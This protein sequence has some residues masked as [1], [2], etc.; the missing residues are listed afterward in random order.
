MGNFKNRID[1]ENINKQGLK[2][3]IIRYGSRRDI[4]IEFEDGFVLYHKLY[5]SFINGNI[6]NDSYTKKE[7]E[8]ESII[9]C[10]GLKMKI[11]EYKDSTHINIQFEDGTIIKD[12]QYISFKNGGILNPN[13]DNSR[14]INRQDEIQM[15]NNGQKCKIINYISAKDIDVLFI[16]TGEVLKH[17][18]YQ[19]FKNGEIKSHLTATVSNVGIVGNEPISDENKNILISYKKWAG[20]LERCYDDEF[21]KKYP[22]YEDVSCC[23]EWLYYS[24]FKK[25]HDDNY[26]TVGDEVMCLDKDI[27]SHNLELTSKIYSPKTCLYVPQRINSLF[28]KSYKYKGNLPIGVVLNGNKYDAQISIL[29]NRKRL[30]GFNSP[31]EAF[32]KGYKPYK[33]HLIKE[34]ADTYKDKIP[35][36]LYDALYR[37]EVEITD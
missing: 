12:R 7:K 25:W 34:V 15:M 33:E 4:D 19:S 18:K 26:Y 6:L 30:Y 9:N 17:M 35:K 29:D 28:I 27:L 5:S 36:I 22:S 24:N 14:V 13:Y 3:K 10:Q 16:E 21:K 37:Y 8:S 1:E 31:E 23:K 11:I 32:Y 20:M 2:M